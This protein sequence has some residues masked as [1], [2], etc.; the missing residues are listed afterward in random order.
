MH[1]PISQSLLPH[2]VMLRADACREAE[3]GHGRMGVGKGLSYG[4]VHYISGGCASEVGKAPRGALRPQTLCAI[5]GPIAASL[6]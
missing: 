3:R 4:S 6:S 1:C 2:K 5:A